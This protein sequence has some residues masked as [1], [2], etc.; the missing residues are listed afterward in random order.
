MDGE[1]IFAQACA[2][3]H[4]AEGVPSP[5]LVARTGVK[6]LTS[7]MVREMSDEEIRNQILRGS[8]N[9]LMP[10][11]QGSLRDEQLDAVVAHI[12]SLSA[13]PKSPAP[14]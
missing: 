8:K 11:F 2:R 1:K 14:K 10:A 6:P 12:R 4:G 7:E 3:C 13:E 5:G 9:R